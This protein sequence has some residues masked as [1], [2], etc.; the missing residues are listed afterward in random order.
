MPLRDRKVAPLRADPVY[1]YDDLERATREPKAMSTVPGRSQE[2]S[3]GRGRSLARPNGGYGGGVLVVGLRRARSAAAARL[4][5]LAFCLRTGIVRRNFFPRARA[6]PIV[7]TFG[8]SPLRS[9]I[10]TP[11]RRITASMKR[12]LAWTGRSEEG[13][14]TLS[15]LML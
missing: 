2:G 13:A 1:L 9:A 11:Q 15:L 3:I 8:F 5:A 6:T 4:G 10:K 7:T 14:R 12:S